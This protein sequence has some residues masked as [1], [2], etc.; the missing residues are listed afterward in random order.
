MSVYQAPA[1][2]M[3]FVV[4]ELVGLEPIQA[5][6]GNEEINADLVSSIIEEA[7][8]FATG[9]LDPLNWPGDREGAKLENYVV[10][11]ATGFAAAYKQ[12]CDGGWG[13]LAN[14]PE[15]GGQ[16]L[17][18][19]IQALTAEMWN[20]SCMSFALCPMLTAGAIQAIKRHGS[21]ELKEIFLKKLVSSEWSGTRI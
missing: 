14:D 11:P 4:N 3:E 7:G 12:F 2:D 19:I 8:K 13:G 6:P 9:V 17:P 10:T 16:G 20:S 21:D 15:W 1:A 18:H 5:L